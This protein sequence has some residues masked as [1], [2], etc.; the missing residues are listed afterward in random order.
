MGLDWT[1]HPV[2]TATSSLYGEDPSL[3]PEKKERGGIWMKLI[4]VSFRIPCLSLH[5]SSMS[6][7]NIMA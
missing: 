6:V 2:A 4:K 5:Q 7:S 1:P 3:V